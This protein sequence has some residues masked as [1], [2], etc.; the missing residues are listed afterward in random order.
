MKTLLWSV[1]AVSYRAFVRAAL[2]GFSCALR[3]LAFLL[4]LGRPAGYGFPPNL[5]RKV[6]RKDFSGHSVNAELRHLGAWPTR[7]MVPRSRSGNSTNGDNHVPEQ[8]NPHRLP[9][10]QRRSPQQQR[11]LQRYH[12]LAG[13]QVLLQEGWQVRLAH[14]MAPLR[15]LRQALGV[16][17]DAYQGRTYPGGRRTAQPGVPEQQ[18]GLEAARLGNSGCLDPE[19]RPR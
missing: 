6:R 15:R 7:S 14:R 2:R 3:Q 13:N 11:G 19:A 9:R 17:Q 1:S 18:D 10:Q 8:S 12:P 4:R 16:R 5:V